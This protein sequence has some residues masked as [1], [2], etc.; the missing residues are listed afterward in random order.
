[1]VKA[2]G[3]RGL[4]KAEYYRVA[5][6]WGGILRKAEYYRVA[7]E[8]GWGDYG[9]PNTLGWRKRGV[10]GITE[11][12]ILRVAEA[13]EGLRKADYYGVVKAEG[14]RGLRTAEYDRVAQAEVGGLRKAE[15][16]VPSLSLG[17]Q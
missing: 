5:E 14:G 12:R 2:E 11:S 15:Y 9:K 10:G 8:L 13:G 6:S 17:R 16:Y 4:R 1:M 7:E 3:G